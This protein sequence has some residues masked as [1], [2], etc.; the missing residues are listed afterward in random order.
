MN[1][2][3]RW[4]FAL[5]VL[6][7]IG[8]GVTLAYAPDPR[9]A[10]YRKE[11]ALEQEPTGSMTIE[12]ARKMI[13]SETNVVLTVRAGARDVNPWWK[14][15]TASFYASEATP[16]S[17][18]SFDP[19]HDP[20]TCPFCSRKWKVEDSMAL[21]HLVDRTGARIPV[22]A[23]ELLGIAEGDMIV[24]QGTASVDETGLLVVESK[25]VFERK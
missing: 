15:E 5:V 24:V 11:L 7:A 18:Y 20:T 1:R 6:A 25:G 10:Q 21:V 13:E 3:T 19:N 8:I 16:G 9:V 4:V 12:D 22:N 2:L 23:P 14:S 17:H